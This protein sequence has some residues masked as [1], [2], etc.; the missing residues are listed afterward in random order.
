MRNRAGVETAERI[1]DATRTLLAEVG[2]EGTTIKAICETAGVRAGSF[3]NLF[4]SKEEVILSVIRQAIRAVD[5]DPERT[6]A[7]RVADLVEAYIRFVS[8]E[9]ALA[10][11]YLTVA[12]SGAVTDDTIR[13][14]VLRHH[15]ERVDRFAAALLRDRPDLGDDVARDV[16]EALL[17]ALNG[18]A[19]HWLL[20]PTFDFGGHARRLL[21]M[22]PA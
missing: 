13:A 7:D 4:E 1:V 5:P 18:Y 16:T 8:E 20:D 14:R 2:L 19:F 9:R 15:Q 12:V 21:A 3:Y 11:V 22:E 6:G 17:A 10:R